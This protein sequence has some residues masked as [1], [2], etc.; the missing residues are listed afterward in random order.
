MI[1][2][3]FT[4]KPF[5]DLLGVSFSDAWAELMAAVSNIKKPKKSS[6]FKVY[7]PYNSRKNHSIPKPVECII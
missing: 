5:V 3:T 6:L 4:S 2:C 7:Y 1:F